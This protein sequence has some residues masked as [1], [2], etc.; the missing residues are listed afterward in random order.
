MRFWEV[1]ALGVGGMVGGGIFAVLGLAVQLAHGG[2]P[3]AFAVAGGV[4]LVT[5]YSYARLSVTFPS[6]G[7]TVTFIDRAIGVDLLAGS[8]NMLLWFS[9]IVMLALYSSALGQLCRSPTRPGKYG[10]LATSPYESQCRAHHRVE[11]AWRQDDW[12]C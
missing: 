10:V 8:L 7:G 2:T 4:A 1:V 5:A 12:S 11:P 9:Y 6:Q 3:V